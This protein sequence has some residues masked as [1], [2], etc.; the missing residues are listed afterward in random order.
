VND[1]EL[2]NVNGVMSEPGSMRE[3]VLRLEEALKQ[4]PQL[5]EDVH[6]HF[7]PG[8]YLR[9]LR[10]PKGAILTG[11]I[12]RHAHMNFLVKGDI[13]VLTEHGIKRLTAPATILS[14]AGIKRAGYAHE[15]TIWITVHENPDDERDLERLE[16][17]YIAPDFA[18]IDHVKADQIMRA[19]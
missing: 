5:P 9:E 17:R 12:H 7:A 18:A 3:K 1:I 13:S 19:A 6:H 16:A 15:D 8:L 2:F 14:E 10:I 11:K 4:L